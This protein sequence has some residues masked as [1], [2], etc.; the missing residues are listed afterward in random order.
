MH[1]WFRYSSQA[2]SFIVTEFKVLLFSF[3]PSDKKK[4]KP[5]GTCLIYFLKCILFKVTFRKSK[6]GGK[7]SSGNYALTYDNS[8]FM[9]FGFCST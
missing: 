3:L 2:F 8:K 9:E 1:R 6:L 5:L 7:A 4:K